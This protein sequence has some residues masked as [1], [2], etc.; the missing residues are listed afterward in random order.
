MGPVDGSNRLEYV[1]GRGDVVGVVGQLSG[2]P[3]RDKAEARG[4]L[5]TVPHPTLFS[6]F[7]SVRRPAFSKLE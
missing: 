2:V 3:L 5:N 7:F 4:P 6:L 1:D